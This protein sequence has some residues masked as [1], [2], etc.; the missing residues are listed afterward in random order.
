M[1]INKQ[2]RVIIINILL[3]GSLI[4]SSLSVILFPLTILYAF[5]ELIPFFILGFS[6]FLAHNEQRIEKMEQLIDE[7]E[8]E[9]RE[10]Y[11]KF[12]KEYEEFLE[13]KK[14]KINS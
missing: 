6:L 11:T 12:Q 9:Y 14:N 10:S 7:Y 3:I 1:T 2:A 5:L 8:K 13:W 4:T